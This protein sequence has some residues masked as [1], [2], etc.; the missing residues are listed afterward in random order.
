MNYVVYLIISILIPFIAAA[1]GS[2]ATATRDDSWYDQ[3]IKPGYNP[4]GWAFG[5]V[6]NPLYILMGISLFL[7]WRAE[8][9][10]DRKKRAYLAFGIQLLLNALW[11]PVFFA[12]QSLWGGV[13]VNVLLLAA[14][15]WTIIVFRRISLWSALLLLPYLAWTIFA[16][17]LN[18]HIAILNR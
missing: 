13:I 12:G 1:I 5:L 4:P 8:D 2:V 10:S 15:F 16:T 3:L 9:S 6:W 14:I 11:S 7:A 18:T 17:I